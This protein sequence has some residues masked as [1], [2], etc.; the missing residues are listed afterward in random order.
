MVQNETIKTDG[1]TGRQTDRL[2]VPFSFGNGFSEGDENDDATE[3]QKGGLGKE[4]NV[5]AMGIEQKIA[6]IVKWK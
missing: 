1:Q 5:F 2:T 4:S 3:A 6:S